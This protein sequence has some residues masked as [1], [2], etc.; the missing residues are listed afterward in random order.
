[1]WILG[2]SWLDW[3]LAQV[4][5][6][7]VNNV[8]DRSPGITIYTL[9]AND[10]SDILNLM[11][12]IA[13]PNL[14]TFRVN[15]HV[16][17]RGSSIYPNSS[18]RLFIDFHLYV[19]PSC[20]LWKRQSRYIQAYTSRG[21]LEIFGCVIQ[22]LHTTN[23]ESNIVNKKLCQCQWHPRWP[24]DDRKR[25]IYQIKGYNWTTT[26][27]SNEFPSRPPRH[28]CLKHSFRWRRFLNNTLIEAVY[29]L[30]A[31]TRCFLSRHGVISP[32]MV[33]FE[34]CAVLRVRIVLSSL[35]PRHA[36]IVKYL[37]TAVLPGQCGARWKKRTDNLQSHRNVAHQSLN[38]QHSHLLPG[39]PHR[40]SHLD[41]MHRFQ[42]Y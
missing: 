21:Q 16:E 30:R 23:Y 5:L 35:S 12:N 38:W 10:L 18:Y 32:H 27:K 9:S 28:D 22:Q 37:W 19:L 8:H 6:D 41:C 39:D 25:S 26:T 31:C 34:T 29:L 11:P 15:T 3:Y 36:Y 7:Y 33:H 24:R 4:V 17:C 40:Y 20:T 14:W 13:I 2:S 42:H 1:M